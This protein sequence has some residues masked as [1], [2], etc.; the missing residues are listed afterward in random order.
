[1]LRESSSSSS[2]LTPFS[3]ILRTHIIPTYL[4]DILIHVANHQSV[5][6]GVTVALCNPPQNSILQLPYVLHYHISA[7]N[8]FH[9]FIYTG[10]SSY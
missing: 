5:R 10:I 4:P 8:M 2:S 6:L 9:F 3:E 7:H 1:M